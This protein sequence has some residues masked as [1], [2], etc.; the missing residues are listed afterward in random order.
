MDKQSQSMQ[1]YHLTS[2]LFSTK[3]QTSY[4][5]EH[6]CEAASPLQPCPARDAGSTDANLNHPS[7]LMQCYESQLQGRKNR[8]YA[9][10]VVNVMQ[11]SFQMIVNAFSEVAR[12]SGTPRPARPISVISRSSAA[13]NTLSDTAP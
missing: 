1:T 8:E 4:F 3:D 9:R 7:K 5:I 10:L 12:Y 13:R 11:A 2:N 6:R